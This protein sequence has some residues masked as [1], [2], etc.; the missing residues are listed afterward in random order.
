MAFLAT[1]RGPP[2]CRYSMPTRRSFFQPPMLLRSG[3]RS[4]TQVADRV[5]VEQ[6]GSPPGRPAELDQRA[7]ALRPHQAGRD[8]GHVLDAALAEP[9]V[10]EDAEQGLLQGVDVARRAR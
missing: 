2:H 7:Q 9:L 1:R 6:V 8:L 5:V 3:A 4:R 10:V